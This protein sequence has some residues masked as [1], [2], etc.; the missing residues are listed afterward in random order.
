MNQHAKIL[1]ITKHLLF[2]QFQCILREALTYKLFVYPSKKYSDDERKSRHSIVYHSD[3]I[4][5]TLCYYKHT[6]ESPESR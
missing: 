5:C 3:E 1:L 4:L 6:E 2:I